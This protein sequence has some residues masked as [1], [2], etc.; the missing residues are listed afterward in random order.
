MPTKESIELRG[1]QLTGRFDDPLPDA[2]QP[3]WREVPG[4]TVV[5][6]GS[7]DFEQRGPIILSGFMIVVP[8]SVA[9]L[10]TDGIKVRGEE[11]EIDGAIG[12]YG[13]KKIFYTI[14]V[15]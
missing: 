9:V 7:S 10:D 1:R 15:N 12:D 14:R 11:H 3:Q 8:S 6:R 5:P 4:A 13:K 2:E